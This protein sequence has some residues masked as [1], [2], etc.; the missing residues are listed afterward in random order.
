MTHTFWLFC[1]K[2]LVIMTKGF[3]IFLAGGG[4][5]AALENCHVFTVSGSAHDGKRPIYG[6]FCPAR[7]RGARGKQ[8]PRSIPGLID[9]V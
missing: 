3:V 8:K 4:A 2:R 6:L 7:V 5:R 9:T 1:D